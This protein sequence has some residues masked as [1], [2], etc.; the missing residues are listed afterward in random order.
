[1]NTAAKA[2]A[3]TAARGACQFQAIMGT[4]YTDPTYVWAGAV[5][6]GQSLVDDLLRQV[7]DLEKRVRLAELRNQLL[8]QGVTADSPA[9]LGADGERL[10]RE[11]RM[12]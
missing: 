10:A 4:A 1:M 2:A 5:G 8:A 7:A 6:L 12:S 3:Y 9:V 11:E